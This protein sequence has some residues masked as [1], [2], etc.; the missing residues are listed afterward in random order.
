LGSSILEVWSGSPPN[1]H[2]VVYSG[3]LGRK[4]QL[5]V[6]EPH[7]V[8][9]ADTLFVEST[10]GNRNHR[11]FD[12]SV[13]EL[14]EAIHFS[15]RNREKV[16]IPAFAVER[17]QEILYVLGELFRQGKIPSMP[18]YLDSPLAIAAT[19]IFRKMKDQFDEEAM[20]IVNKGHDPFDFPQLIF[21]RTTQE[22]VAINQK[23]GPAIIVAGN[24]MCTA[25]RI[26]HHLKHNLWRQ[27]S[28]L[29][30]VGFQAE[31]TVGRKIVDGAQNV[32]IFGEPIAVKAKV[33]T[34]GGFSAHAD[35]SDLLTWIGHFENPRMRIYVIHGERGISEEFAKLVRERFGFEASVPAL[36]DLITL[37]PRAL[38]APPAAVPEVAWPAQFAQVLSKLGQ[39]RDLWEQAPTS[40]RPELAQKLAAQLGSSEE[41]LDSLLREARLPGRTE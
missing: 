19:E 11:S 12:E 20:A 16:L 38:D 23:A 35:Q 4:D 18:V 14:T 30:I 31:G 33:F 24:G 36:G 7:A 39:L 22:S 37:A 10:Y 17:T 2:K 34:I 1:A 28:S 29:V 5:I 3:D 9:N 6:K 40:I 32:R 25:G 27:G 26:K 15:Y 21:S 13:E 41:V 8:F